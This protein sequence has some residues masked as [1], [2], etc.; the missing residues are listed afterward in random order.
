LTG[1]GAGAAEFVATI[2][3]HAQRDQL[4]ICLHSVQVR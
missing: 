1:V 4:R 3:E 2:G